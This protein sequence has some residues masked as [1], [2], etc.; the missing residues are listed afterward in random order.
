MVGGPEGST[1][2]LRFNP[3]QSA[4]EL[5]DDSLHIANHEED[6][7]DEALPEAE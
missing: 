6:S 2:G 4:E 1:S 7:G 3:R 5:Q